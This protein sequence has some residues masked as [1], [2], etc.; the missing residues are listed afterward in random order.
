MASFEGLSSRS[1]EGRSKLGDATTHRRTAAENVDEIAVSH[2][3]LLLYAQA[4][5]PIGKRKLLIPNLTIDAMKMERYLSTVAGKL[6]VWTMGS[7]S[8][9]VDIT[10]VDKLP[11]TPV[12]QRGLWKG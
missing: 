12:V 11:P 6:K 7:S 2:S 3:Q 1:P 5:R 4:S 8:R 9:S 10:A